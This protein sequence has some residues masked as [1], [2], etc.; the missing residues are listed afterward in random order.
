MWERVEDT[1]KGIEE[2]DS[3]R[4][5]FKGEMQG[6]LNEAM[7]VLTQRNEALEAQVVAMRGELEQLRGEL[8]ALRAAMVVG[9]V[10]GTRVDVPKPKPFAGSRSVKDVDNFVWGMEQ[11]F[12]VAGTAED[13]KVSTDALYLSDV[14]L[15]WWRRRCDGVRRGERP[16]TTWDEFVGE[17][18]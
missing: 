11:Y 17:L 16:V 10:W 14:A 6:A 4:E 15:L 12:R 5:E 9:P 8:A 2:L 18:R 3:A 13:A 7:D 1:E